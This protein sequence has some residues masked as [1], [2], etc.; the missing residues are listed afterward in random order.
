MASGMRTLWQHSHSGTPYLSAL[1]ML[2]GMALPTITQ[3]QYTVI[4]VR[5]AELAG[6]AMA[7]PKNMPLSEAGEAR[8]QRLA[9][10]L[11]DADISAIYVTDYERTRKTAAPL[12]TALNISVIEL[13]KSDPREMVE[14]LRK[15]HEGQT[16]LMVGHT[17]T[18]PGLMKTMGYPVDIRIESQD[19]GS[20]FILT[21]NDNAPPA[22]LRLK[23]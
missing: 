1:L 16:V 20:M 14:R 23:Y 6:V 21:P 22:F 11:K 17:D 5:H 12:A 9:F 13:P 18:L 8:A 7:E 15:K 4:L 2:L 3:A 19:Y 10:M